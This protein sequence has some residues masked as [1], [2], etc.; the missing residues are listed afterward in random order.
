MTLNNLLVPFRFFSKIRVDI[1]SKKL[2]GGDIHAGAGARDKKLKS[3]FSC[4]TSF[5]RIGHT[6]PRHN[7]YNFLN[8]L[9]KSCK[10]PRQASIDKKEIYTTNSFMLCFLYK[11]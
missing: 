3:K 2:I 6:L 5:K 11:L 8:V 10:L 4:Q 9:H 7:L 1:C